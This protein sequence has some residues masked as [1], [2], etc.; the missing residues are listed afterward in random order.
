MNKLNVLVADD[1]ELLAELVTLKL[2]Q[3][4]YDVDYAQDGEIALKK[5]AEKKPDAIILDGMMPGLD[6]FDVLRTLKASDDTKD[7]PIVM[8]TAR[9]MGKDVVNGLELGAADYLVKPFM[10][11]ELVARLEKVLESNGQ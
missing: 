2:E 6:G 9:G 7:I 11:A 1:D 3:E 8:L 10:P 5:V 4:G